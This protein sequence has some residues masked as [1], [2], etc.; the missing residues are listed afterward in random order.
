[1]GI[2]G[3]NQNV[4]LAIASL[5][6]GD[7]FKR[8]AEVTH[9]TMQRYA[10][11][12]GAEFVVIEDQKVSS[13]PYFEKFRIRELL[14][15]FVRVIFLDTVIIVRFDCP[16]PFSI[17]SEDM[18]DLSREGFIGSISAQSSPQKVHRSALK[19]Y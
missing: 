13:L 9:P 14:N 19:K 16:S 15:E 11:R 7:N 10:D 18:L 2:L 6:I 3:D 8:M 1:M 12:I 4:R 17:V 5:V